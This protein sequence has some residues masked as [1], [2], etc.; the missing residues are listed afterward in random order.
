[1]ASADLNTERLFGVRLRYVVSD[2]LLLTAWKHEIR[3]LQCRVSWEKHPYDCRKSA[4]FLQKI[5]TIQHHAMKTHQIA[6]HDA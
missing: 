5:K 1:M 2:E 4:V 6:I 3:H